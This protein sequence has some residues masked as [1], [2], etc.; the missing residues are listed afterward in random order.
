[1]ASASIIIYRVSL[2]G[3]FCS[4]KTASSI[5]GPQVG[6]HR[7]LSSREQA[8]KLIG[9]VDLLYLANPSRILLEQPRINPFLKLQKYR[10]RIVP[11]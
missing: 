2:K 1:M 10:V 11:T 8:Y 4:L 7:R 5:T 6:K 9:F 3:R